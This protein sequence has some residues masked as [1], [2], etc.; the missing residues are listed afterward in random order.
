VRAW[1]RWARGVTPGALPQYVHRGALAGLLPAESARKLPGPSDE[2]AMHRAQRIYQVLAQHSIRTAH[3]PTS[4]ETGRQAI[5][6]Q[7]EVL[8]EP[9]Q[10]TCLDIA[11]TF[12]GACL[13]AALHPLIVALDSPRGGPGHA[14]VLVWLDGNWG[15]VPASDYPWPTTVVHEAPPAEL[16][17]RVRGAA[18]QSGSFLAIDVAGA[19][20]ASDTEATRWEVAIA[21]G[22]ELVNSALTGDGTWRWG[23]AVDIGVGWRASEPSRVSCTSP[24]LGRMVRCRAGSMRRPG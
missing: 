16:I 19:T 10:A 1:P 9:R 20:R 12:C 24:K 6:T 11:V 21:R 22:A 17:G 14:V 13:D 3:E 4:S 7:D 2:P 23:T 18:D 5:R 8:T 15:G